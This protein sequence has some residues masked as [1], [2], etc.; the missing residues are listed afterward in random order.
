MLLIGPHV[1]IA[2]DISLA[3]ERAHE[4]GATGFAIFTKNQKVWSAKPLEKGSIEK[5]RKN[6]EKYSYLTSSILPHAGYLINPATARKELRDK[7]LELLV[8]EGLRTNQLGINVLNLHPGAYVEGDRE[9]G[10]RRVALFLD[11]ALERLPE[12]VTLAIENT[13]GAGTVLGDSLEELEK[14]IGL[15]RYP[16]RLGITLDTMH[17]FGAGYDVGGDIDSIM[18]EFISRFGKSKLKG[19]HLNDSMVPRASH[20]DRHASLG[21]GLIGLE[22]F[23]RLV[24]RSE[25]QD[26]PLILETPNEELWQEE[27]SILLGSIS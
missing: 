27:I 23:K 12:E 7:S 14:I 1:S 13:A 3:V 20:K 10:I 22:A 19:M 21:K 15:S 11:E 26:I 4:K 9:E 17:L 2:K 5:F 6:L 24:G 16:E 25:V 18:D 8:D